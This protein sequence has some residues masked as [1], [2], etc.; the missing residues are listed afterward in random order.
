MADIR[1]VEQ[2]Y[3]ASG[4]VEVTLDASASLSSQAS[5]SVSALRVKTATVNLTVACSVST[6]AVRAV[7]ISTNLTF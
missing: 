5:L 3:V 1:Y 7:I 4:Y 2:G 6:S